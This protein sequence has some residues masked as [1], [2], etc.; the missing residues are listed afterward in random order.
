MKKILALILAL[1]MMFA[2]C[3]TASA[4]EKKPDYTL[5]IMVSEGEADPKAQYTKKFADAVYD[6]TD[7]GLKIEVY[8]NSELGSLQDV[9]E[10]IANGSNVI[11]S[12][13]ID[14]VTDYYADFAGPAI[15]F[16]LPTRE[17]IYKFAESDLFAQ[18]CKEC[19]EQSGIKVLNL[20]W[21]GSARQILST[22]P[23]EHFE[24]LAGLK[25]RCPTASYVNFFTNCGCA[26]ENVV[27]SEMYTALNQGLVDA[28]EAPFS[29]LYTSSL[30][31]VA[32]N[33][34]ESAHYIPVAGMFMN[35]DVF[36]MLPEEYQE[37][38]VR[39]GNEIGKE[40]GEYSASQDAEYKQAMIDAGV[41]VYPW[42]EEDQAKMAE[43]AKKMWDNYPD[44]S[45]GL[46]DK[47]QEAL[48]G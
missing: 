33:L 38:I 37:I 9:L 14:M 17:K 44:L 39:L 11:V 27:W 1:C 47:I 6:E 18:M 5:R 41:T 23:V 40:F 22:K 35:A 16:T 46:Y 36:N 20:A 45:E 32:K 34:T 42:G 48:A 25:M 31:E 43:A 29:T 15:F 26:T 21:A 13:A 28:C 19:E 12:T 30:Q 2:L 4:E 10:T 24:D 8:Y 3:A 7:G